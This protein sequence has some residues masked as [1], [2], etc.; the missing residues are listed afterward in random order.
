MSTTVIVSACPCCEAVACRKPYDIGSG[1]EL[2]CASCEWCWGAEG[3]PLKPLPS[4][5]DALVAHIT[6]L[7]ETWHPVSGGPA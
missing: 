6:A 2:S 4:A 5:Q 1:P 7:G 3:Q